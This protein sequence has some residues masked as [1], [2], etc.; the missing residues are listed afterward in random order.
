MKERVA[1]KLF[2]LVASQIFY[3]KER[4]AVRDGLYHC[5]FP[6]NLK[7]E[8]ILCLLYNTE[9]KVYEAKPE[10]RVVAQA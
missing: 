9:A 4:R 1:I 3:G 8:F 7:T 2:F 6:F 5:N 10:R